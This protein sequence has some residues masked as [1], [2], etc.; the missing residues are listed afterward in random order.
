MGWLIVQSTI[1]IFARRR[2]A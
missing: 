2:K 1:L